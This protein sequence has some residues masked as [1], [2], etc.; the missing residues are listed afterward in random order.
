MLLTHRSQYEGE[1]PPR[2]YGVAYRHP[3]MRAIVY[4]LIPLNLFARWGR[5]FWYWV[6]AGRGNRWERALADAY[7]KGHFE[8]CGRAKEVWANHRQSYAQGWQAALKHIEDQ[9]PGA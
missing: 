9:L 8:G 1:L 2:F 5:G 4:Y 7:S 6:A 3:D